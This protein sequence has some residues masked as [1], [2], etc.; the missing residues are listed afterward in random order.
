[1]T[2]K[3]TKKFTSEDTLEIIKIA[4]TLIIG[5]ILIKALLSAI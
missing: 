1:M 2:R 4:I 3:K 5:Y